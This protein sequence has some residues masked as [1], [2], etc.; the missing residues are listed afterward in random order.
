MQAIIDFA[1]LT[2]KTVL[3]KKAKD[4]E[5]KVIKAQPK[6]TIKARPRSQH[7]KAQRT[8]EAWSKSILPRVKLELWLCF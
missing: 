7:A 2:V 6:A 3:A 8:A 1:N 5:V 4:R